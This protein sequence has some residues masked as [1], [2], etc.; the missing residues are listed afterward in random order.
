MKQFF[1]L[2]LLLL[3]CLAW[4]QYPSNG[5]QKITLGEQT[6]ADG[7]IWRGVAADTTTTVKSDTAA[8][9][10]LDTVNKKLYFYKLSAIPKWNEI[11]GSGGGA[12]TVTSITGGIGLT[13]GTI[14]TSGTLAAD[15]NFLVTRYDTASMLTNYYRS[16]RALGTPLSGVLTNVTGLPLTTGVTGTLAVANGG[17]GGSTYGDSTLLQGRGTSAMVSSTDLLFNYT[18]KM[19]K[20]GGNY[21][22]IGKGAITSN[23]HIGDLN[24]LAANTTGIQNIAIGSY[25]LNVNTT[26][27]LNT[28][29]GANAL[30]ANIT[31]SNNTSIGRSS[32][33]QSTGSNNIGIGQDAGASF[34]SGS[35]NTIIGS[36]ALDGNTGKDLRTANNVTVIGY[37]A[38]A[39]ATGSGSS[40]SNEVTIGNSSTATYRIFGTWSN[41][42]DS[43][44]KTNILPLNYGMNYIEKLKPVS[45][46]WDM[47]DG[48]KIGINDIG[49]IAQDLKQS[50]IDIGINIPNLISGNDEKLEA[51]YGV[52]IPIIVKALQEANDKIKLL[53]QRIFNLENK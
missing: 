43:R 16:G 38:A 22:G 1:S 12:G 26:G 14:T 25:T 33:Q 42:S 8:Y 30:S 11:S 40:V 39:S 15:T 51:A 7:L 49:F 32:L 52:L 9:F 3:P 18:S 20:V 46:V 48:G 50:Q 13:G 10:V 47:R 37:N 6:T 2:F 23:L 45:F 35:G 53:E 41:V 19:L 17:T 29:I 4:A 28:G 31:G 34:T 24:T 44:D 36:S 27:Q 21:F 5:N